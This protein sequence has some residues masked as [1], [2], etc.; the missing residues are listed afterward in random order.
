[1]RRM[2]RLDWMRFAVP[3]EP[4]TE[5]V[6]VQVDDRRREQRQRLAYNESAH[7]GIAQRP[8]ELG[9]GS[10]AHCQGERTQ[11]GSHG[12]NHDKTDAK[13]TCLMNRVMT[14]QVLLAL[15]LDSKVD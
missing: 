8:A 10:I 12:G 3:F 5:S 2:G 1:M 14:R 15:R 6:E 4:K 7:H 13:P 9:S 11:Q